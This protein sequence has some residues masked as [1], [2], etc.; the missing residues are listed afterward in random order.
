MSWAQSGLCNFTR[1]YKSVDPLL[2]FTYLKIQDTSFVLMEIAR[3]ESVRE[4]PWLSCMRLVPLKWMVSLSS[5]FFFFF[6]TI[7]VMQR[8]AGCK[9]FL[10]QVR[11]REERKRWRYSLF[12]IFIINV[13]PSRHTK[14]EKVLWWQ[15]SLMA[16]R[17]FVIHRTTQGGIKKMR[18]VCRVLHYDLSEFGLH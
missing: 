5:F 12:Q 8:S 16:A 7:N 1:W 15:Q 17:S 3:R 4:Y 18:D 10:S 6:T 11:C 14:N 9:C 13:F 2:F